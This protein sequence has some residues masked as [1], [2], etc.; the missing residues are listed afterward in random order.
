MRALITAKWCNLVFFNYEVDPRLLRSYVPR[1]TEL[2]DWNGTTYVS[3][4]GFQFLQTRVLG[5]PIPF[6]QDFDEVNLRFYVRRRGPDGWRR[7]VVFISEMVPRR[8]VATI[9]NVFY[10][11]HYRTLPM[12]HRIEHAQRSLGAGSTL[13][14]KWRFGGKWQSLE[15]RTATEP[16]RLEEGSL[17]QFITEHYWGYAAARSGGTIE[18]QVAHEP[19]PVCETSYANLECD[20]VPLYGPAF[21]EVLQPL[22]PSA[23][24]AVGSAVAIS[25]SAR[26]P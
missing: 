14:Y 21:A 15:A 10:N 26:L 2:D 7:A 13:A 17:T 9:A 16:R 24:V 6:H 3:V 4:V 12:A 8:A 11:E 23:F 19:W 22:P 20:V 5:V 25:P 18:Y 1:G